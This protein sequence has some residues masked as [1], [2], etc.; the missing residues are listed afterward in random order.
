MYVYI[1]MHVHVCVCVSVC[2]VLG[3][4]VPLEHHFVE[5]H[6]TPYKLLPLL[7]WGKNSQTKQTRQM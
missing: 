1:R 6:V 7:K 4:W 2:H 3:L 5:R